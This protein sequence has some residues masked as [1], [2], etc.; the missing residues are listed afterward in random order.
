MCALLQTCPCNALIQSQ[1]KKSYRQDPEQERYPKQHDSHV[2]CINVSGIKTRNSEK[3]LN[4]KGS[5]TEKSR[6]AEPMIYDVTSGI[7]GHVHL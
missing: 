4:C 7:W 1:N 2:K 3:A 5:E 6:C